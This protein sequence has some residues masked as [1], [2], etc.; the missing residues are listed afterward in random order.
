MP[1]KAWGA[2]CHADWIAKGVDKV[3]A[4]YTNLKIEDGKLA[5]Q[6]KELEIPTDSNT[7]DNRDARKQLQEHRKRETK[8][9]MNLSCHLKQSNYVILVAGLF[10]FAGR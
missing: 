10:P 6:I 9:A 2:A 8:Y 3:I 5:D 4:D 1:A 7:K